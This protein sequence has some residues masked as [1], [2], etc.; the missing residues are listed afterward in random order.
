MTAYYVHVLPG[1]NYELTMAGVY[2]WYVLCMPIYFYF[3]YYSNFIT[4][5][6]NICDR[7]DNS[8]CIYYYFF[9]KIYEI[10]YCVRDCIDRCLYIHPSGVSYFF[11]Y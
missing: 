7:T 9:G 11:A 2:S 4:I 6:S 8:T 1:Q 5:M 10:M 3:I